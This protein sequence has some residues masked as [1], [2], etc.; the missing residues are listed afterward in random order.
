M[1]V[2]RTCCLSG[3][4]ASRS[5]EPP[6]FPNPLSI[7]LRLFNFKS[8]REWTGRHNQKTFANLHSVISRI[9]E[10]FQ[11]L[12]A[13]ISSQR[14]QFRF[15]SLGARVRMWNGFR[16]YLGKT[17][18]KP[19]DL[20]HSKDLLERSEEHTSELQSLRH[21]VCRLLL[22]KKKQTQQITIR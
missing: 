5:T 3:L 13:R 11:T 12:H 7:R 10:K 21:L 20:A 6:M 8:P 9:R 18:R 16:E 17:A 15:D 2:S 1:A 19:P 22:E 4:S 14:R